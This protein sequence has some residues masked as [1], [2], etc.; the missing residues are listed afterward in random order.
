MA[1]REVRSVLHDVSEDQSRPNGILERKDEMKIDEL[2]LLKL[3]RFMEKERA[4][5]AEML[6]VNSQL[7]QMFQEWVKNDPQ[8]KPLH[9]KFLALQVEQ[10][11]AQEG[12]QSLVTKVGKEFRID[13]QEFAFDDETGV[14][15]KV[16]KVTNQPV[17][18]PSPVATTP[19]EPVEATAPVPSEKQ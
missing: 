9:E 7:N 12:Y 15:T 3:T 14:L 10:K 8:G 19:P 1:K 16:D 18:P 5:R 4:T 2:T 17:T 6:I 13:M 11:T